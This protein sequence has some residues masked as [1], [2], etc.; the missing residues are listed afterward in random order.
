MNKLFR[1]M[2]IFVASVCVIVSSCKENEEPLPVPSI[3]PPISISSGDMIVLGDKIDDPYAIHNIRKAYSSLKSAGGNVPV[4]EVCP[5]KK[6][7]RFL[8]KDETEWDLLKRDTTLL[9]FDFPLNFEI[10]VSGS[11][12]HDPELP[13]NAITWQYCVVPIDWQIPNVKHELLYEVFIPNEDESD[14]ETSL[15]RA[16]VADGFY[17]ELLYESYKLTGNIEQPNGIQTKGLFKP[18]RWKPSGRVTVQDNVLGTIPLEGA[19]VHARWTTHV[20]SGISNSNG[21]FSMGNFIYQVNYAVKWD[22]YE[23]SIRNGVLLQAW[24]D[25]PKQKGTWTPCITGQTQTYFATIH[26]AAHQYYYGNI[27]GLKKPPTNATLKA[28]MKIAAM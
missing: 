25:G 15:K 14:S 22:R 21:E 6:Y 19:N 2:A 20:A 26:R 11:Y 16:S 12:Y 27:G 23:Y 24:Y 5:N 9:L 28:Q 3:D 4:N 8:P 10:A 17:D 18:K 7:L 13:D 1:K